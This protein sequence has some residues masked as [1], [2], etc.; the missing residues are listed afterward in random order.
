MG[1]R[2][3]NSLNRLASTL[4]GLSHSE[5]IQDWNHTEG[6]LLGAQALRRGVCALPSL[7]Q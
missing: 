6:P 7:Q 1:S 2:K 4:K 3:L 5:A